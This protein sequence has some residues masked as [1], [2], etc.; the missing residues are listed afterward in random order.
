M[1]AQ[2]TFLSFFAEYHQKMYNTPRAIKKT[3]K[4][5]SLLLFPLDLCS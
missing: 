1:I 2:L 3:E 5:I 4:H